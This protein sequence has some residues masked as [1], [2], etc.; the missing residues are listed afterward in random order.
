VPWFTRTVDWKGIREVLAITVPRSASLS[1][2]SVVF[3]GLTSLASRMPEGSIAVLTFAWNL[4]SVP[5][6]LIAASYSVAAFPSLSRAFAQGNRVL[7][8]QEMTAALR[9]ILLWAVPATALFIVL[10]A[11]VVRVVLGTGA[12]DWQD[13]RL[14]AACLGFFSISI[15]FQCAI[16]LYARACHAARQS[17]VPF[18]GAI[19]GAVTGLVAAYVGM[20]AYGMFPL[21]AEMLNSIARVTT[22]RGA[23]V[24]VL[25]L[26]YIIGVMVQWGY[27]WHAVR[28]RQFVE[29]HAVRA[30]LGKLVLAALTIAFVTYIMLNITSSF[31][32]LDTLPMV[33]GHALLSG[34]VGIAMGGWL[35]FSLKS[36]ELGDIV[37]VVTTWYRK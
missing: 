23:S 6:S 11:H 27:V 16:L 29:R 34:G 1:L 28:S 35:L 17:W 25:P 21:F 7:F 18:T 3:A 13:T 33:L 12:F 36:R 19:I 37:A 20:K 15:V 8:A 22:A 26:G 5:L 24:V 9:H 14:T 32:V 4:Q 2:S 30:V 31:F 10:R